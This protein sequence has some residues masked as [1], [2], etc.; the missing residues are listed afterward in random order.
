[1]KK[2]FKDLLPQFSKCHKC[3]MENGLVTDGQAVPSRHYDDWNCTNCGAV[4][5]MFGIQRVEEEEGRFSSFVVKFNHK[6][7]VAYLD[8]L[9]KPQVMGFLFE[10]GIRFYENLP[11][12]KVQ[13][14][15]IGVYDSLNHAK[16]AH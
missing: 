10:E 6:K 7:Y 14:H 15:V 13:G 1:M 16:M 11:E 2:D 9:G 5:P 4:G 8:P 12:L 3:G